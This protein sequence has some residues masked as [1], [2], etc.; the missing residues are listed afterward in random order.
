MPWDAEIGELLIGARGE[1]L[2]AGTLVGFTPNEVGGVNNFSGTVLPGNSPGTLT[3]EG[4]YTQGEQ[5][6]LVIELAGPAPGE[7]YDQ[8]IV[9][10][11]I[12]L[13]GRLELVFLNGYVPGGSE[14]FEFLVGDTVEGEFN[15]IKVQG[16]PA[17]LAAKIRFDGDRARVEIDGTVDPRALCDNVDH[18]IYL[19]DGR[20]FVVGT[21]QRD[22]ILVGQKANR[23]HVSMNGDEAGFDRDSLTQIVV[24]G[25]RRPDVI[26]LDPS[27]TLSSVLS[28]G[29]GPDLIVGGPM[30]DVIFGGRGHDRLY[31]RNGDD[32]ISGSAHNDH[33]QG[34][35]GS[36]WLHGGSGRDALAGEDGSDTLIGSKGPDRLIGGDGDDLL[37][38]GR[39]SDR[40][41]G[42]AGRDLL[43]GGT[44]S[45]SLRG[46]PDGDLL[47]GGRTT[48]SAAG[49]IAVF[50]EWVSPRRLAERIANIRGESGGPPGHNEG[51]YLKPAGDDS[52]DTATLPHDRVPDVLQGD[53]GRDWLF[54]AVP[55]DR[56]RGLSRLDEL[57]RL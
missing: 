7:D 37:D 35:E 44:E 36:D 52:T 30:A 38:G 15:E 2:G 23:V 14:T 39:G 32:T 55:N 33:I 50:K 47:I 53:S 41:W 57:D 9:N 26:I 12:M 51:Y 31:G 25:R 16:L 6:T 11:D 18:G 28:G 17:G 13:N 10:G 27:L 24:C 54:A 56:I 43:I 48:L 49:L 46:G 45:D 42:G 8:L 19:R 40:L 5:G 22:R 34:G 21:S 29:D 1:L 3:I 20:L 4:N